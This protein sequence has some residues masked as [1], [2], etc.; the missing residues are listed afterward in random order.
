MKS[1][2]RPKCRYCGELM[3]FRQY[4]HK[5]LHTGGDEWVVQWRCTCGACT[6]R[7][8]IGEELSVNDALKKLEDRFCFH[9]PNIEDD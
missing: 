3:W 1:R 6:P 4:I 2:R 9:H 7:Q 8:D 5:N